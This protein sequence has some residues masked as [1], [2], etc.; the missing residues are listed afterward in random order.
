M[1][2]FEFSGNPKK[3]DGLVILLHGYGSNGNDLIGLSYALNDALPNYSFIAPNAPHNI[4]S[5]G[6]L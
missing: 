1:K 3:C 5:E 4:E 2:T 6:E